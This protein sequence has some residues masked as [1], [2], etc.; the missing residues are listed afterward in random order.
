M[1]ELAVK[2]QRR[3]DSRRFAMVCCLLVGVGQLDHVAIVVGSAQERDA[4]RQIVARESRRDYN[5][6]HV[7][8]LRV[9][10]RSSL[11]IDERRINAVFDQR[12]LVFHGLVHNGG[13]LV[14]GH[15]GEQVRHE[16]LAGFEIFI[17]GAVIR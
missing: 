6:R 16:R 5:R 4:G 2:L 7:D 10:V 1:N 3:N 9:N 14:I 15:H 8:Q 12:R 13:E 11:L 17:V